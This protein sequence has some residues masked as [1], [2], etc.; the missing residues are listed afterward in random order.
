[1]FLIGVMVMRYDSGTPYWQCE[2]IRV[3]EHDSVK[4]IRMVRR[5]E[6][7]FGEGF[8]RFSSN[9]TWKMKI[10]VSRQGIHQFQENKTK[11]TNQITCPHL[12]ALSNN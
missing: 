3:M 11:N 12:V 7:R 2:T 1:M 8:L 10:F 6:T 5:H 9:D 4:L